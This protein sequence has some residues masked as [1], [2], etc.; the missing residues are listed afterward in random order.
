MFSALRQ[1]GLAYWGARLASTQDQG[2]HEGQH[3]EFKLAFFHTQEEGSTLHPGE[4]INHHQAPDYQADQDGAF[5]SQ[6]AGQPATMFVKARSGR[7]PRT[8]SIKR[9]LGLL[10]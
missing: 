5:R 2:D 8:A 7:R 9:A 10:L 4:S 3:P 6:A 1:A